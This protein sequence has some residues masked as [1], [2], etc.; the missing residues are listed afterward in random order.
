M[1]EKRIYLPNGQVAGSNSIADT[2][3]ATVAWVDKTITYGQG[4]E[5]VSFSPSDILVAA[6]RMLRDG[7][8]LEYI[9]AELDL[10][11][12]IVSKKMLE[13]A[14][15]NQGMPLLEKRIA[16][17]QEDAESKI[18]VDADLLPIR[19]SEEDV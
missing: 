7:R 12:R 10:D 4:D 15:V 16:S 11:D 6:A 5:K 18:L 3:P 13:R 8:S 17:G 19:A 2:S 9:Y 1:N 14:I